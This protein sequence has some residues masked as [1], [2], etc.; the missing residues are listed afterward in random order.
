MPLKILSYNVGA[1]S[2]S[3]LLSIVAAVRE[4]NPD[5]V[6]L[7]D[8]ESQTLAN[9]FGSSL[10]MTACF[11]EGNHGWGIVWLSKLPIRAAQ[12]HPLESMFHTLLQIE[13]RW[14]GIPIHLF[15]THLRGI[16]AHPRVGW[17]ARRRADEAHAVLDI[18]R[19]LGDQLLVLAGDF[20]ASRPG[21][22]PANPPPGTEW[23]S[24]NYHRVPFA[25]QPIRLLLEAGFVDCYRHL[26]ARAGG[27]TI[28]ADHPWSRIDFVFASP[29]LGA[30]LRACD[31]VTTGAASSASHH[32]PIWA[33]FE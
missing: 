18:V 12:N 32:F 30:R 14:D 11:G 17:E 19:P 15:A 6:A 2:E 9:S 31:V 25:R 24:D 29:A 5:V 7:L 28:R 8:P 16:G 4:Q 10:G 13:V 33:E 1:Q 22:R 23:W 26:H 3:R 27:Y 20:N 21:E